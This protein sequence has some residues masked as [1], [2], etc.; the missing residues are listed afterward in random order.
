MCK[1][2][3][4]FDYP[5]HAC[6]PDG[7]TFVN[8]CICIYGPMGR[9]DHKADP[10]GGGFLHSYIYPPPRPWVRTNLRRRGVRPIK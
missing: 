2:A 6:C 4:D 3:G 7:Y 5:Q 10:I 1:Q 8:M 9:V